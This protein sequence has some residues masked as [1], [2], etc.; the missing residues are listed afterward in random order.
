MKFSAPKLVFGLAAL[1]AWFSSYFVW[2]H[3]AA[4]RPRV[5]QPMAIS[6][7]SIPMEA[8]LI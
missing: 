3:Y 8:S 5:P 6:I 2:A 1:T 7:P 4:T